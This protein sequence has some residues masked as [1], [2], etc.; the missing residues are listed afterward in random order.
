MKRVM[1]SPPEPEP[2]VRH[3]PA[4]ER[5]GGAEPGLDEPP[6]RLHE[7]E[8]LDGSAR[9]PTEDARVGGRHGEDGEQ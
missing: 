8:L 7:P 6:S 4:L 2:P 5:R 9:P 1:N 3:R